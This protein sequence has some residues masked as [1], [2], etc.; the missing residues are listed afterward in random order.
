MY[1]VKN[2]YLDIF[3]TFMSMLVEVSAYFTHRSVVTY[4]VKVGLEPVHKTVFGLSHILYATSLARKTIDD[5]GALASD[6]EF[7]CVFS[8]SGVASDPTCLVQ[9]GA[10]STVGSV[11]WVARLCSFNHRRLS[12]RR[13]FGP[14]QV[15][16]KIF[17]FFVR[18]DEFVLV[19]LPGSAGSP[20]DVPVLGYNGFYPLEPWVVCCD[21]NVRG[22]HR[23]PPVFWF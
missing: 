17:R 11:A 14:D 4:V 21:Q 20:Q 5:I 13:E 15:V 12:D 23:V 3:Q 2:V 22:L 1:E 19:D 16:P 10:V 9:A 18:S 6:V 8:T 7:H